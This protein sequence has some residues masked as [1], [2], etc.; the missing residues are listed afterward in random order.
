MCSLTSVNRALNAVKR[1]NMKHGAK[2][3]AKGGKQTRV[4]PGQAKPRQAKPAQ[5]KSRQLRSQRG[6]R[7]HPKKGKAAGFIKNNKKFD[8]GTRK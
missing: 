8:K 6:D 5:S 1:L 3:N 4:K 7:G 2:S